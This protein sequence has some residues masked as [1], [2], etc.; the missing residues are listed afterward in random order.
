MYVYYI[1]TIILV[2]MIPISH[3]VTVNCIYACTYVMCMHTNGHGVNTLCVLVVTN[4]V[5]HELCCLFGMFTSLPLQTPI[6]L[7]PDIRVVLPKE[8]SFQMF[9]LAPNESSDRKIHTLRFEDVFSGVRVSFFASAC[10]E[11][12]SFSVAK[13]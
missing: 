1:Y 10:D 4:H 9:Y 2:I 13:L 5:V 8:A 11:S 7:V 3:T 12:R 6:R